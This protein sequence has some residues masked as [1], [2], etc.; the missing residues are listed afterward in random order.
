MIHLSI[1][2]VKYRIL[3][4]QYHVP[5]HAFRHPSTLCA[6]L[7]GTRR[8]NAVNQCWESDEGLLFPTS[9]LA[10]YMSAPALIP[11]ES[12]DG[13]SHSSSSRFGEGFY[14]AY[15]LTRLLSASGVCP[16]VNYPVEL[17]GR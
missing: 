7:S 3:S 9:S 6:S 1:T 16:E 14:A 17:T 2:L 11:S 13:L 5:S 15:S 10:L 4:Y 8:T 12:G